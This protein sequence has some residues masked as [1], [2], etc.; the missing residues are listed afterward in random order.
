MAN[1]PQRLGMPVH[2]PFAWINLYSKPQE[3]RQQDADQQAE[4]LKLGA[5]LKRV[6]EQQHILKRAAAY[7]AKKAAE[8]RQLR[9]TR[10]FTQCVAFAKTSRCIPAVTMPSCPSLSLPE[11]KKTS[12][13]LA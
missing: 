8:V 2:N 1:V 5:E 11:P 3:Q 10:R 13:Y 4:L 12:G 7:F 9:S 6:T